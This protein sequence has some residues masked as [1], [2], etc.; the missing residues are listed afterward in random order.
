[1]GKPITMIESIGPV[2]KEKLAAAGVSTVEG[3]LEKGA[4]KSGRKAIAEASG[5]D[6]SKILV[7]VNMADLFRINGVASQFAEL[8]K[9]AGVD[10]VKELRTRN[11]ENLHA[12]LVKTQEEKGL[13]RAVPAASKVADFIEQAK[14]LEPMV[15]H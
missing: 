5:L 1:M 14:A 3:L 11:A 6:E 7:W 10:T 13:T 8:L 2:M 4:S 15:T 9:A 12:A